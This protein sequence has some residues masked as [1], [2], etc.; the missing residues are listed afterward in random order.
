MKFLGHWRIFFFRFAKTEKK[1]LEE[2]IKESL[3][4]E[5]K[6]LLNFQDSEQTLHF[7]LAEKFARVVKTVAYVVLKDFE[8]K[9]MFE[10]LHIVSKFLGIWDK[11]NKSFIQKSFFRVVRNAIGAST[12]KFC[13]KSILLPEK[14]CFLFEIWICSNFFLSR[15]K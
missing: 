15:G 3:F 10:T 5:R 6:D 14:L 13:G 1:C 4:S 2:H 8:E 9:N 11:K 12:G 7:T